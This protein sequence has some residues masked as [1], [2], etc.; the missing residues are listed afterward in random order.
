MPVATRCSH[1]LRLNVDCSLAGDYFPMQQRLQAQNRSGSFSVSCFRLFLNRAALLLALA[2]ELPAQSPP[3]FEVASVKPAKKG[4][5]ALKGGCNGIDTHY[6][7]EMRAIAPPLGRCV[8]T[9]T[10]DHLLA[11]AYF[12]R[13]MDSLKG[14]PAWARE[15]GLQFAIEAK[16]QDPTTTTNAELYKMLQTLLIERFRI[17]LHTETHEISG[18]ALVQ[19]KN[20]PKLKP[21]RPDEAAYFK[22]ISGRPMTFTARKYSMA[23]LAGFLSNRM[24]G[25]VVDK[26]GLTGDYDLNFTWDEQN[27]PALVTILRELGLRLERTKLPDLV[28]VIES[29]Q[30]PAE[31]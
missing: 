8:F 9:G 27:G 7:V 2:A 30:M 13:D 4:E 17:K 26:T 11:S 5:T 23:R 15:D 24:D 16:A 3:A 19:A 29:A 10:L 20:G 22:V 31:N 1:R 18:F 28:V 21:S 6:P 12:L 25:G 14:A